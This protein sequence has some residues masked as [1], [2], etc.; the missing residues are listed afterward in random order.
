M[1]HFGGCGIIGGGEGE[2]IILFHSPG[3]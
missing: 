2:E 3:V 1:P